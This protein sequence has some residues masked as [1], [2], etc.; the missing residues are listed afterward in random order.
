MNHIPVRRNVVHTLVHN[1]RLKT[2]YREHKTEYFCTVN[3]SYPDTG[4]R[5]V[6]HV[7]KNR[8]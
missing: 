3:V 2:N 8:V 1:E 4:L 6:P 7:F 5:R